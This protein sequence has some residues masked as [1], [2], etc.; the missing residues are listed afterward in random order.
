MRY[1]RHPSNSVHLLG[2]KAVVALGFVSCILLS[3]VA[4][5]GEWLFQVIDPLE[6]TCCHHGEHTSL[7]LDM[8][9][10]PHIVYRGDRRQARLYYAYQIGTGQWHW[11]EQVDTFSGSWPSLTLDSGNVPHISYYYNYDE[12][13]YAYRDETGWHSEIVDPYPGP[14][15]S[16]GLYSALSLDGDAHPHILYYSDAERQEVRYARHDGTEWEIEVV[17]TV[18]VSEGPM[19]LAVDPLGVVHA[20]YAGRY[21]YRDALGW[22]G[23]EYPDC[24]GRSGNSLALDSAGYPHMT[25]MTSS[26]LRYSFKDEL[27]WHMEV[28]A[29]GTELWYPTLAL[30]GD[31]NPHISYGDAS[32]GSV[33]YAYKDASGWHVAAIET[34]G[35]AGRFTSLAA[36]V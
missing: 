5:G 32:T 30:D 4:H 34:S 17:D 36:C 31:D 35:D 6:E 9:G 12:L 8:N 18:G 23:I 33:M 14:P 3:Q 1:E 28:V 10:L 19:S 7:C 20:T 29:S 27:G 2:R 16:V 22:H 11:G 15:Y 13:K 24:G 26:E 21:R 25:G